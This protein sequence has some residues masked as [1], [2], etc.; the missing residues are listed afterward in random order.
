MAMHLYETASC[1][2]VRSENFVEKGIQTIQIDKKTTR[3]AIL[4]DDTK[5]ARETSK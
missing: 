2:F 4:K 1:F 3:I 5:L